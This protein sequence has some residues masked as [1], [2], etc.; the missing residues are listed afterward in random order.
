MFDVQQGQTAT[1]EDGPRNLSQASQEGK[2]EG[3]PCLD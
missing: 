2:G 3:M 1:G